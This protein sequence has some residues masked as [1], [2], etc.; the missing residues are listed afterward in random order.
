[1][2]YLR[3]TPQYT[4][5]NEKNCS[6]IVKLQDQIDKDVPKVGNSFFVLPPFIGYILSNIGKK[7]YPSTLQEMSATLHVKESSLSFFVN[8]LLNSGTREM[9]IK[10]EKI[11]LPEKLL[12]YSDTIDERKYYTSPNFSC[13]DAFQVHRP[14]IPLNVTFMVTTKCTTNC[15]YCYAKRQGYKEFCTSEIIKIIQE[16]KEIGVVNLA[17]TGGDIFSRPDWKEILSY[18]FKVGYHPFL[19]TKTILA[20]EELKYLQSI[21]VKEIQFSLDSLNAEVLSRMIGRTDDYVGKVRCMFKNCE[22][23]NI[24]IS[25]RT[26]ATC[27]N[28]DVANFRMLYDFLSNFKNIKDWVIT[29]AFL[30]EFKQE[31]NEYKPNIQSLASIGEFIK[32]CQKIFPIY[33]NKFSSRGY[34]LKQYKTV[35]QFVANNQ[36]CPANSFMM[37]ILPSGTCTPCEMLYENPNYIIGNLNDSS[38]GEIWNSKKALGL[39]APKQDDFNGKDTVCSSCKVFQKCRTGINKRI[40]LVDISKTMGND[41]GDF[42]DPKCPKSIIENVI[43]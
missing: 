42:P 24:N 41:H 6:F 43:L 21:G 27:I 5:R 35:E 13:Q 15:I 11:L 40:C 18:T 37:A 12:V 1:M 14:N 19:S 25:V 31:V 32:T 36:I 39:F 3:L 2:K 9:N 30:S 4:I 29:P 28:S 20:F 33:L 7:S 23:N 17:L 22:K 34:K 26:V 8:Q 16:C 38:I 10:T